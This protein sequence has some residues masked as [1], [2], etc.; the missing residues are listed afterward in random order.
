MQGMTVK[1]GNMGKIFVADE[2]I[3][4]NSDQDRREVGTR[5]LLVVGKQLS[6]RYSKTV[7]VTAK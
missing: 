3:G 1:M 2:G 4:V 7:R 5:F 6:W